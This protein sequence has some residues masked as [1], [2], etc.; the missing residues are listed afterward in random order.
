[1]HE[2]K[3]EKKI[4]FIQ[5]IVNEKKIYIMKV[6]KVL[7]FSKTILISY[8]KHKLITKKYFPWSVF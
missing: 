7:N 1:M 5:K 3:N 8:L 6:N 2:K 4:Y